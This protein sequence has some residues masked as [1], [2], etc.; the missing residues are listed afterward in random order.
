MQVSIKPLVQQAM[1]LIS[2]LT[3]KD[4]SLHI[5]IPE[6]LPDALGDEDRLLQV[7]TPR[8]ALLRVKVQQRRKRGV[9]FGTSLMKGSG[10]RDWR[11]NKR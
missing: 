10:Y 9:R 11:G 5:N 1:Q 2:T 7:R 6:D 3:K 8:S 4:V